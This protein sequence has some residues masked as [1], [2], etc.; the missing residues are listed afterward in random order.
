ML[1]KQ[2]EE[3]QENAR[4]HLEVLFRAIKFLGCGEPPQ[5]NLPWVLWF[6]WCDCKSCVSLV[7][8][9]TCLVGVTCPYL[10]E[11]NDLGVIIELRY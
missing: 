8:L 5:Q 7:R 4:M 9:L 6:C 10:I 2:A 1:C 11:N 3:N